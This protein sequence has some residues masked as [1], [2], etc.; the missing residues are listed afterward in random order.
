VGGVGGG[1]LAEVVIRVWD[2]LRGNGE[3]S[4]TGPDELRAALA[5][6]LERALASPTAG[7]RTE[8]AGVLRAVDAVRVAMAAA[9]ETAVRQS[10][11]RVQAE[12]TRG[13]R[14]TG[15]RFAEFG[16]MLAEV[17]DQITSMAES[18]AEIAAGTRAMLEKQHLTLMQLTLLRRE[19]R[20]GCPQDTNRVALEV[21]AAAPADAEHD[22]GRNADGVPADGEC[23]YPGLAAFGA[24]NAGMFFG[25]EEEVTNLAARLAE[26]CALPGLLVVIGPSG[27]GKSSLL[28]AGL[29]PAVASGAVPVR[30]SRAWPLDLMTPGQSPLM[31]LAT[32]VATL[33][34]IPAGR[35]EKDLR[36]DPDQ[37]TASVRQA[38]LAHGR[39]QSALQVP[40]PGSAASAGERVSGILAG[41]PAAGGDDSRPGPGIS[42]TRLVLVVD[43]FEEVFTEC[44]DERERQ[45]F[46]RALVT[47]AGAGAVVPVTG[48]SGLAGGPDPRLVPALVVIGI[49][50]DFYARSATYPELAP[51]LQDRPVLVGPIS[52]PGL[53]A[54]IEKPAA[55]AGL[56]VETGLTDVMLTDLGQHNGS[57]A[58][59]PPVPPGMPDQVPAPGG[60]PS[61]DGGAGAIPAVSGYEAGRLPLLAHALHQIWEH[62][63]GEW[64]TLAAYRAIGGIDG[65]VAR[66]AEAVYGAL[67][68]ESQ[69]TARRILLRMVSFGEDTADT[70]RRV[71]VAELS[72]GSGQRILQT[73]IDM[74]VQAR[75]LTTDTRMDRCDTVEISHEALLWAWPRMREWLSQCPVTDKSARSTPSDLRGPFQVAKMWLLL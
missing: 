16:W 51:F 45:A 40:G 66:T 73:V 52:G 61:M 57:S 28:R 41:M 30:G 1:L 24:E 18:Q 13:F 3:G 58:V 67:N 34:G 63:E 43:Q 25:R 47:A 7:L 42:A 44:G 15:T 48:S 20:P 49:R 29:L 69:Q 9:V 72:R 59:P 2:R 14:D 31:E 23:P 36:D 8:V 39:R 74:F 12:L 60:S 64:L 22:A 62:R 56:V 19:I 68:A 33:A 26:L 38:M 54:A 37:I 75:L 5:D 4:R 11:D 10:G 50:A 55:H 65:A 21:M 27:S 70:R 6:E 53:R 32:R 17:S 35:L 46:I 71:T